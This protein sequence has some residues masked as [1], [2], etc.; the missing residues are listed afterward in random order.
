M[1]EV[2]GSANDAC[3]SPF[4]TR[5]LVTSV[6][7]TTEVIESGGEEKRGRRGLKITG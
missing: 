2:A 1:A 6:P 3:K 5:P 4:R 7:F